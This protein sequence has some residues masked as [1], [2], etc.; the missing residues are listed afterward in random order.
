MT[1]L[2]AGFVAIVA[3]ILGF[4][5]VAEV[6]GGGVLIVAAFLSGSPLTKRLA[7]EPDPSRKLVLNLLLVL[8]IV[9]ALVGVG[10]MAATLPDSP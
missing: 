6:F 9:V 10:L 5:E 1:S 4:T 2:A 8:V 3:G 7:V